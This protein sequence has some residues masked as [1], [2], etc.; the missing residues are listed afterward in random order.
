METALTRAPVRALLLLVLALGLLLPGTATLPLMD[1]DEPRFA[2]A[3]WEMMETRQWTVPYFNGDYRFD[4]PPLTYW[5]MRVHYWIF[6][7]S[8]IGARLHSVLAA[9][10]TALVIARMGTFLFSPRAGLLAGIGFLTCLQVLIHG[11]LC[12]ADMPMILALTA[13]M[14]ATVRL[15]F[16]GEDDP[17]PRRFGPLYWYLVAALAFG[18]LAK[19][20]IAWAVPILAWLLYCWPFAKRRIAW[21]RL[22]PFSAFGIALAIVAVWGLPAMLET[23]WEFFQVGIGEH[24]VQRGVQPLNGRIPIFGFYYLATVFLSLLPWAAL[25]HIFL[26]RG[27]SPRKDDKRALLMAW[28]FAPFLIFSFYAT[29]LPHYILPGFPAFF[30]L[31]FRTGDLP[32]PETRG[33][34][35]SFWMVTGTF[36]VICASGAVALLAK[37][38]PDPAT[39]AQILLWLGLAVF[40]LLAVT[41]PLLIAFL[42]RRHALVAALAVILA[43]GGLV[44]EV[45]TR[46]LREQHLVRRAIDLH[47]KD[48]AGEGK[49]FTAWRFGEPSQ[50]FYLDSDDGWRFSSNMPQTAK[51]LEEGEG[52]RGGVFLSRVWR[53]GN[54]FVD[55]EFAPVLDN[56]ELIREGIDA[57]RFHLE[58][59]QGFNAARSSW[60][61]LIVVLPK[62]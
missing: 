18:F 57:E 33:E 13:T 26:F 31:L 40:F 25:L 32:R 28:F 20:P 61:E 37:P 27:G 44:T 52:R 11:R 1:R 23:N 34:W 46:E 41:T 7:K 2:Q 6:G 19:G 15:L 12:V 58:T 35:R 9:W 56:W 17:P 51:W 60:E 36:V 8:E 39:E 29:Q 10:L 47:L 53:I 14:D 30:L 48:F 49:Q 3:T 45:L 38:L 55:P 5:W 50:V 43:G 22:Q 62:D 54:A 21:R 16:R 42:P 59:V 4:K 24:V